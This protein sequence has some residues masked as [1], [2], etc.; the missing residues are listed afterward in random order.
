MKNMVWFVAEVVDVSD[1]LGRVKVRCVDIH[2]GVDDNDLPL[3]IV[4]QTTM[5]ASMKGVGV[6]PHGLLKGSQVVGFFFDGEQKQ[7]PFILCSFNT[8]TDDEPDVSSLTQD[9]YP[10]N[11]VFVTETGHIIEISDSENNSR[12]H[13]KHRTGTHYIID[14]DGNMTRNSIKDDYQVTAGDGFITVDG[15]VVENIK[16]DY[17]LNVDG[18]YSVSVKGSASLTTS[19]SYTVKSSGLYSV[20]CSAHNMDAGGQAKIKAGVIL[21]N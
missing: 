8:T 6:S 3:A 17:T 2:D 5:S 1:K 7:L 12:I 16:G 13:I 21:L 11:K 14:N 10:K 9:E 19:S 18:N 20:K 15:N 4:G